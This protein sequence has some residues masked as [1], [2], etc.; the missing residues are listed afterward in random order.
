MADRALLALAIVAV[1][2]FLAAITAAFSVFPWFPLG[3]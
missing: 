1:F 2:L 3:G